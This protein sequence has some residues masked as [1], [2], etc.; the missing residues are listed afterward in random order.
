M[1]KFVV[2][3]LV[4]FLTGAFA[5]PLNTVNAEESTTEIFTDPLTVQAN[6]IG[7]SFTVNINISNVVDLYA[8]QTGITFNPLVLECVDFYEGEFLRRG[9]VTLF[10]EHYKDVDNTL[11]IVYFRGC[12][13]LGSVPGVSESGQLASVTF[14]SVGIGISDFHLTDV[15]LLNSELAEIE[16]EV[17]ESFT[18]QVYGANYRVKIINNL[19]G[20]TNPP[21]PPQ[22]GTFDLSFSRQDKKIS[23]DEYSHKDWFCRITVPKELLRCDSLS[24]WTIKVDGASIS[25]IVMENDTHTSL[26][27]IHGNG[28]HIVEVIG[29]EVVEGNPYD[30]NTNGVVDLYDL[31]IVAKAYGS[32]GPDIPTPGDSPSENWNAKADV[33]KDKRVNIDDLYEIAKDYGK[34][35]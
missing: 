2:L 17:M 3:I 28:T 35:V 30:L 26:Y 7:Q 4:V 25:Y 16:F 5:V 27:F 1:T 23:F 24:D 15:I 32:H 12:C 10:L 18:V 14:R 8:W 9:G 13:L 19:T 20:I 34:A 33:N 31:F 6:E 22:S 21:D 11:G 29:T